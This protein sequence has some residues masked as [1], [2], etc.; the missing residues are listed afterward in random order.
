MV[1]AC[2]C[3]CTKNIPPAPRP[4]SRLQNRHTRRGCVRQAYKTT[5]KTAQ[6]GPAAPSF[7][8]TI[9]HI[10]AY[11]GPFVNLLCDFCAQ[12]CIFWR[13]LR[14]NSAFY[15]SK[16]AGQAKSVLVWR[17]APPGMRPGG[18]Q[19]RTLRPKNLRQAAAR[20]QSRRPIAPPAPQKGPPAPPQKTYPAVGTIY[21][22]RRGPSRPAPRPAHDPPLPAP[23]RPAPCFSRL[24]R[25][26]PPRAS[27][28]RSAYLYIYKAGAPAQ[29]GAAPKEK[30][31]WVLKFCVYFVKFGF[32]LAYENRIRY[33]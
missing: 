23:V 17:T 15:Q 21:C 31:A 9:H 1:F 8:K 7:H 13:G 14:Q 6:T 22:I 11:L 4:A 25:P 26:A 32:F 27:P 3:I 5:K 19:A 2:G 10:V 16:A 30:P 18:P 12:K 28:A 33:N 20:R 29:R 24:A